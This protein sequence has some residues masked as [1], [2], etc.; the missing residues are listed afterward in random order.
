MS[1]EKQQTAVKQ[2]F[3]KL[4]NT[5]KDKF[6]WYAILQTVEKK[7]EQE[8]FEYFVAGIKCEAGEGP[9]FEEFHKQRTKND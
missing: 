6:T 4:W 2:L 5:S 9:C 7:D 3:H 8:K 1:N